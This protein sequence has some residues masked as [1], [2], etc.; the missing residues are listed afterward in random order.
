MK[1]V[2]LLPSLVARAGLAPLCALALVGVLVL[3][4]AS[5]PESGGKTLDQAIAEA[6]GNI[7]ERIP[8]GSKIALLNFSSPADR[9]SSYVLD[10]LTAN[11]IDSGNLTVVNR[12]EVELIRSEVD[13][14]FSGE[15]SDDSIQQVGQM[16]G[17]QYIVSGSLTEIGG[18]YRIVVR[19][20]NVES[21]AVA[22]NFRSDINND[23][24]VQ[25]LL[26]GGRSNVALGTAPAQSQTGQTTVPVQTL[27]AQ[28][29]T[30]AY[31]IGDTGPAGGLV[32]YDKG[33]SSGG[34]RYLEVAES[35]VGTVV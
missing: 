5:K 30:A 16:L 14:Q 12:S 27:P 15:V 7:N 2:K 28:A 23:E 17:A 33:N 32:F 25:A 1:N 34:W 22:A 26:E 4:C 9:F 21:A 29:V 20:L 24:R 6:A 3:G 8:T 10:E 19:V 13:F 35:D 31:N 18:D 11:L